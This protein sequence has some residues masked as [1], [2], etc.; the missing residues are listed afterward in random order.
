[1]CNGFRVLTVRLRAFC[2]TMRLSPPMFLVDQRKVRMCAATVRASYASGAGPTL[3]TA[4]TGAKHNREE[5]LAGTS[6]P[7]PKPN[8]AG[9]AFSWPKIFRLEVT[10]SDSTSLSNLRHRIASAPSTGL[11]LWFK[12]T[13]TTYGRSTAV[14]AADNGTTDDAT[15]AGYTTAPTSDA[16]YDAGP[17]AASST[18]GKGDYL[19]Y[20]LGVSN[21]YVGGAGSAISL[22]NL[23]LTYDES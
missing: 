15:P 6:A 18:G 7:I 4:E 8:A 22:P 21:L 1:M 14:A 11:K 12:D 3:A 9:T 13:S 2:D 23:I 20:A 10:S 17:H 19:D 16:Q 5:T